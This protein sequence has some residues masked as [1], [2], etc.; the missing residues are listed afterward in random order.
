MWSVAASRCQHTQLSECMCADR[1]ASKRCLRLQIHQNSSRITLHH[2][3]HTTK[4]RRK[5]SAVGDPRRY[6]RQGGRELTRLIVSQEQLVSEEETR[7]CAERV[8][9]QIVGF[10]SNSFTEGARV[11]DRTSMQHGVHSAVCVRM[12]NAP[13]LARVPV[14]KKR[15]Q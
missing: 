6:I 10:V 12:C 13:V 4:R 5:G 14:C 9:V 15:N 3:V 8:H 1:R 11:W 2:L 7:G